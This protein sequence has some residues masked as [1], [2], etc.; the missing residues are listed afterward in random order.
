MTFVS[1]SEQ[2][3]AK[4]ANELASSLK[5]N[6]FIALFGDMGAGKT[7]FTRHLAKALGYNGDVNSPTFT[8]VNTYLGGKFNIY[9]FDM[10]RISTFEDLYSTGFFEYSD[11][12]N[13]I[14]IC[15]WSE[16]IENVLP[17]NYLKINLQKAQ[18]DTIRV[19]E[20]ENINKN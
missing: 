11:D 3:T 4:F 1:K 17:D 20:L 12:K 7:T 9:H 15:E 5:G 10:Y 6:D 8:I 13:G 14:I 18:N 16:N 19:F 2:D